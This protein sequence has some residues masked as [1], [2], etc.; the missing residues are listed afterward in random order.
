MVYI[1]WSFFGSSI[2]RTKS[3]FVKKS[4][5]KKWQQFCL[6]VEIKRRNERRQN[7][8]DFGT[9]DFD[10]GRLFNIQRAARYFGNCAS[11]INPK[12]AF[13]I[14]AFIG[15]FYAW[16]DSRKENKL[17][18]DS[19]SDEDAYLVGNR[20]VSKQQL[21]YFYVWQITNRLSDVFSSCCLVPDSFF[22]VIDNSAFDSGWN[23]L[24]WNYVSLVRRRVS[25]RFVNH[26]ACLHAV[27]L[28]T[29]IHQFIS[30]H[31]KEI[32]STIETHLVSCFHFQCNRLCWNRYV[33]TYNLRIMWTIS[34]FL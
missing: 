17:E 14:Q 9:A 2:Q 28:P 5:K 23:L 16:I 27:F 25:S 8:P 13:S 26:L 20:S 22:H 18:N 34:L 33:F 4:K 15:L 12:Q 3:I 30:I 24:F 10:T 1:D 19:I 31:R 21:G 11:W 6:F 29:R 32:W 7:R